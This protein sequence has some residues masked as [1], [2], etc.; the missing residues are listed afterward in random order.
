MFVGVP[1]RV[2]ALPLKQAHLQEENLWTGS[3]ESGTVLGPT[4]VGRGGGGE[5]G[6]AALQS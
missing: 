4:G 6:G 1:A 2:P 3:K 5:G